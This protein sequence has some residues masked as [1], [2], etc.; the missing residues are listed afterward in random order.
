MSFWATPQLHGLA[1]SMPVYLQDRKCDAAPRST[2]LAFEQILGHLAEGR[3]DRRSNS[4]PFTVLP[5]SSSNCGNFRG[6]M[7]DFRLPGQKGTFQA[8]SNVVR[9]HPRR[10]GA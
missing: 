6:E 7:E 9:K 3:K 1:I 2:C 5:S 4:L 10:C 8:C